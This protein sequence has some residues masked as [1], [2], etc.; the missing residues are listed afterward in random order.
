M[1]FLTA[2]GSTGFTTYTP[3]QKPPVIRKQDNLFPHV[4]TTTIKN[5][6]IHHDI[7]SIK[8]LHTNKKFFAHRKK[9]YKRTSH[10]PA[11]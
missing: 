8:F 9:L 10:T 4:S 3:R 5:T 7:D 2:T 1:T 11:P 6:L